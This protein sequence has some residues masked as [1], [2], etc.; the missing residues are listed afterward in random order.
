MKVA[1]FSHCAIDTISIGDYTSEQIGGAACYGGITARKLGLDVELFTKFGSDFPAEEYLTN[2]KISFDNALSDKPTTR[3]RIKILNS[4]RE[5]FLENQCDP[6][7]FS[8]VNADGVVVCPIFDEV[9]PELFEKIKNDSE[10]LF[11]DP[12]GFLRRV[13]SEKKVYLKKTDIKLSKVSAIKVGVDEISNIVGDSSIESMKTLNKMGVEYVLHTNKRDISLLVKDKLYSLTLPNKDI[14]DTTGIGDIFSSTFC[15]TM[16]KEKDFLWAFCFAGGAAQAALDSH[17][18]GL[19]KIPKK[20]T[21]QVNAS[22]F[23][24]TIKFKQI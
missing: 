10:F 1:I 5:M 15:C 11:L 8:S 24:N 7:E 13:D 22:Y 19:R 12:Q 6:L 4:D 16:L 3:F 2:N 9:S 20:G 14:H 21:V 17:E 18:M 23:Y